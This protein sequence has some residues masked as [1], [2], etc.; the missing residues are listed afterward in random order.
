MGEG[1]VALPAG[2]AGVGPDEALPDRLCSLIAVERGREV[3]LIPQHKADVVIRIGRV[4]LP[5]GISG[6]DFDETLPNLLRS[7]EAVER[8]R[9]V[10]LSPQH[11]ANIVIRVGEVVLPVGIARIGVGEALRFNRAFLASHRATP[12]E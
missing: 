12:A 7:P 6:I 4:M 3:A 10:A 1:K 8:G 5:A 11:E 9:E 2:I